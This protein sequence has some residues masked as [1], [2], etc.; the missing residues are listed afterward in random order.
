MPKDS[1]EIE[2]YWN[3]DI[4]LNE[5][6]DEVGEEGIVVVVP[7]VFDDLENELVAIENNTDNLKVYVQSTGGAGGGVFDLLTEPYFYNN[8]FMILGSAFLAGLVGAMG[9]DGWSLIKE[10]F[11]SFRNKTQSGAPGMKRITA[12]NFSRYHS[13]HYEFPVYLSDEQYIQ[14][15]KSMVNHYHSL[16]MHE[17]CKSGVIIFELNPLEMSWH[18]SGCMEWN[19]DFGSQQ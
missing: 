6:H 17:Y 7:A 12:I 9:E 5:L 18:F 19:L 2:N 16:K 4:T 11:R 1:P 15:I 3:Y 14:A 13:V 8:V 10:C